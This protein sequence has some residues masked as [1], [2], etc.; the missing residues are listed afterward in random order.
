MAE[1]T[2]EKTRKYLEPRCAV[3]ESKDGRLHVRM[4]M[5][6][7]RKEDLDIRVENNEMRIVGRRDLPQDHHYVL[8]ERPQGD[9]L[10]AFTLDETVDQG[11]VDAKL[12]K[13]VLSV[14]LELKEHVKP[15]TVKIRGE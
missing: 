10:Q 14:T 1:K 8:R 13:G 2:V 11:K 5:P 7:V 15:R 9:F 3:S 12:E 4:E 6:G